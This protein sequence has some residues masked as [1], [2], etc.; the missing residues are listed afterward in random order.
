M[1]IDREGVKAWSEIIKTILSI[2][3]VFVGAYWALFLYAKKDA[4]I[5]EPRFK[6]TYNLNWQNTDDK[7]RASVRV[8]L[9]NTGAASYP[10]DKVHVQGWVFER[11]DE[12]IG[13]IDYFELNKVKTDKDRFFDRTYNK[14]GE[15]TFIRQFPPQTGTS[16][17]FEWTFTKPDNRWVY[18][19]V[20]F[21]KPGDKSPQTYIGTWS[22]ICGD[23]AMPVP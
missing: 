4:P 16:H 11:T 9:E 15:I 22:K 10:I 19:N 20:D 12:K 5:L 14:P 18:F 21:Y 8:I 17:D 13:N 3:A 23:G 7:C 2:V 1:K 6:P